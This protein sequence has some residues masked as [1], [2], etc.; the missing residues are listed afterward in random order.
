VHFALGLERRFRKAAVAARSL[1]VHPGF[2]NT[3]LQA[4][5]VRAT[6]G[7]RSQRFFHDAV[8]RVGMTPAR[9][10]LVIL[11]AANDPEAVGGTLYTPRWVNTGPPVRRPLLR[12]SRDP[13]AIEALWVVSE[14]ETGVT[15]RLAPG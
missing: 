11:R 4:R 12:R 1:V 10:A 7:G 2:V 13:V 9:G 8:R 15:Y 14:R 6:G 5:S 3:D